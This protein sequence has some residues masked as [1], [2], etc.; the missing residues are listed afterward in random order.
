MQQYPAPIH[1]PLPA[2]PAAPPTC[3]PQNPA[4]IPVGYPATIPVGKTPATIPVGSTPSAP[5]AWN[6][7]PVPRSG[8]RRSPAWAYNILPLG[9]SDGLAP[10]AAI[11]F[12]SASK[13]INSRIFAM[14]NG[15]R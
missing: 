11:L 2:A 10:L 8:N 5:R 1:A 14:D 4:T 9:S 7:F 3:I 15:W 6:R 12:E 13:P